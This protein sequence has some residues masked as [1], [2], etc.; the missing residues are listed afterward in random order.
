[1]EKFV[2]FASSKRGRELRIVVGAI[3]V[4]LAVAGTHSAWAWV[5]GVVGVVLILSGLLKICL[6]NKLVGRPLGACPN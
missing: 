2:D 4:C 3:L 6:F 1:M 5:I